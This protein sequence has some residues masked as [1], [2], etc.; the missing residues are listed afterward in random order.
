MAPRTSWKGF[1][2]LSLVSVPVKAFT[3][4]NS[5]EDVRLNQLHQECNSRVKYQKI[6]PEHGVLKSDDIVSGYEYAKDEYVIVKSDE[7]NQ[8][9]KQSDKSISIFGF[10]KPDEVDPVYNAGRTYYLAPDGVVGNRPYSLLR[11]GMIA[12]GVCGLAQIVISGREQLVLLRPMDSLLVMTVLQHAAKVKPID[13]FQELVEEQDLTPDEMK[14]ADTLIQASKIEEFDYSKYKDEYT[15]ELKR[16]IRM[17]VDG[18]EIVQAP[19]LEEP[20]ILNLM[21]ALKQSVAA[22]QASESSDHKMASSES[23]KP[24]KSSKKKAE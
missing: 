18:Q 9:R 11:E 8:V 2:K 1:I 4:S 15:G 7:L 14:L 24:D 20:K 6:C 3:S 21:D 16:L 10:I 12:A 5:G 23:E 19:D 17:K 13:E 22:A